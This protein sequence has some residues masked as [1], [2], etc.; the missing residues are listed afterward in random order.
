MNPEDMTLD[1]LIREVLELRH[2]VDEM[3]R[4]SGSTIWMESGVSSRTGEGFV[5]VHWGDQHGQLDVG[6]A[7]AHSLNMIEAAHAAEYDAY[8]MHS[9][10][11]EFGMD[12]RTAGIVLLSMRKLR[13]SPDTASH[14]TNPEVADD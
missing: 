6:E 8:L 5:H 11:T 12:R 9:L 10:T 7:L 3:N 4:A 2:T 1:E 13:G 14:T